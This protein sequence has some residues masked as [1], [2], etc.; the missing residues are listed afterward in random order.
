MTAWVHL[1]MLLLY[2]ATGWAATLGLAALTTWVG[3][4]FRW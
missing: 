4:K 1:W 2:L 3:R